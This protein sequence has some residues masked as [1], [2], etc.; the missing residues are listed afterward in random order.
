[1]KSNDPTDRDS[2]TPLPLTE[3]IATVRAAG[4]TEQDIRTLVDRFY[5]RVRGDDLIG[6]IFVERVVDW[7]VHLPKMCDFWSTV[8]RRTGRYSGRPYEA[9]QAIGGLTPA[10]FD[11]WLSLWESTVN[12]TIKPT[13][14][15]AFVESARRMAVSMSSR[16]N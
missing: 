16:L 11:R 7:S 5:E 2:S 9:H 13:A 12:R 8:V 4:V 14:R 3:A 15:L 6:P 10:H 1:M